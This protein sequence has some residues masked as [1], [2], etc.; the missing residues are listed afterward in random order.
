MNVYHNNNLKYSFVDVHQFFSVPCP[1]S[2]TPLKH[3]DLDTLIGI[4]TLKTENK[5][6]CF[7]APTS[8]NCVECKT[9]S[10][11]RKHIWRGRRELDAW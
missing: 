10:L 6:T 4:V 8:I 1:R 3:E 11:D 7:S 9:V 5:Y 2:I